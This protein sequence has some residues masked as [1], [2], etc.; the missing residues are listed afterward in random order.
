[1]DRAHITESPV[2]TGFE[3]A[4]L[5]IRLG[6]VVANWQE[7]R[8]LSGTASAGVVKADAYGVG[9]SP[10]ARALS[11]AGCDIFFVARLEEGIALRP[12]V[13]NARIYVLDGAAPEAVPALIAHRLTPVLNSLADLANWQSRRPGGTPPSTSIPG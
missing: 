3:A 13:P 11:D 6:A 8:R 2:F 7:C 12:I 10:V 5:D 4:R 9:L 1:M